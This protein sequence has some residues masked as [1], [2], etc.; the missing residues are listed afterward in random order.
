MAKKKDSAI[1]SSGKIFFEGIKLYFKNVDKF[2]GYMAF[3]VL[4]Q[5]VG[6]IL[7]FTTVHLFSN[8]VENPVC[9]PKPNTIPSI[10]T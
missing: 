6:V 3:P 5:A 8:N 2:L 9:G 7:I 10:S 1:V 4:G